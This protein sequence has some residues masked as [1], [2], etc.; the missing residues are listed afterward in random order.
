MGT[1]QSPDDGPEQVP[2]TDGPGPDRGTLVYLGW[3]T[4]VLLV[5]VGFGYLTRPIWH[6]LVYSAIYS[7]TGLLVVGG[8]S[9]AAVILWYLPP[10]APT[11]PP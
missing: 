9:V 4:L 10:T 11:T 1:Q 6:G 3:R 5:V 8:G 7:P 2:S